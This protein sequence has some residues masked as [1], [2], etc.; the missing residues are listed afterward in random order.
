[1][2]LLKLSIACLAVLFGFILLFSQFTLHDSGGDNNSNFSLQFNSADSG[3]LAFDPISKYPFS[4]QSDSVLSIFPVELTAYVAVY[5]HQYNR[6]DEAYQQGIRTMFKTLQATNPANTR[7]R[8]VLVNSATDN[9]IRKLFESDGLIVKE[10]E[11]NSPVNLCELYFNRIHLWQ[12]TEYKRVVMIESDVIVLRP[13]DEL[14]RCGKFCMVYNS[15]LHFTDSIFVVEP[16]QEVYDSLIKS[17]YQLHI[18]R[19]KSLSSSYCQEEFW[20]FFLHIFGD[21]EAAPL[22]QHQLAKQEQAAVMRMQA[23][24]SL[25]A[26]MWYE[27]YSWRLMRSAQFRNF[28]DAQGIPAYSLSFTTLKPYHWIPAMFF[29][30]AWYWADTRDKFL[31]INYNNFI[32]VSVISIVILAWAVEFGLNKAFNW[33]Y[34][35]TQN[36]NNAAISQVKRAGN[37]LFNHYLTLTV[38]KL[39]VSNASILL[40]FTVTLLCG[41]FG[42][43]LIPILIPAHLAWQVYVL[44]HASFL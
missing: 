33:L 40:G 14:F 30:L 37:L 38:H 32:V 36:A 42:Q 9:S 19:L 34:D 25:N 1:M 11:K 24:I 12:L 15:I 8:I 17:Y 4:V 16:S 6:Y 20:H 26:M 27:N 23:S 31:H 43:F 13:L 10:I 28:T 7:S 3:Q 35:H 44:T 39:N 5:T 41:Y 22:F 21:I 18:N 29:N 2:N